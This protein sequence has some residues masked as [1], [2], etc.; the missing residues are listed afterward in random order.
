LPKGIGA[1]PLWQ[2]VCRQREVRELVR[3]KGADYSESSPKSL[4]HVAMSFL[5]QRLHLIVDKD[6]PCATARVFGC[7]DVRRQFMQ[8]DTHGCNAETW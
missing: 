1:I 8:R 6:S 5:I 4:L 3:P 7:S 2:D